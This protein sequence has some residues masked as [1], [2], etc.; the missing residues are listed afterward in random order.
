MSGIR[1]SPLVFSVMLLPIGCG[2]NPSGI[3]SCMDDTWFQFSLITRKILAFNG[4]LLSLQ[5]EI[6]S[7][8]L[9]LKD[10]WIHFGKLRGNKGSMDRCDI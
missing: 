7:N 8:S 2:M 3:F 9:V 4:N 1:Y 10:L 5:W 6:L